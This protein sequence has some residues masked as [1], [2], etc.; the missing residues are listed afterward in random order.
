MANSNIF[1]YFFLIPCVIVLIIVNILISKKVEDNENKGAVRIAGNVGG[2]LASML[3]SVIFTLIFTSIYSLV[4]V[5]NEDLSHESYYYLNTY[6]DHKGRVHDL[7]SFKVYID[8]KTD[9]GLVLYKLIYQSF[10]GDSELV[11]QIP[12]TGFCEISE[13]PD[14]YWDAPTKVRA[15][16]YSSDNIKYLLTW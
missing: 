10:G 15:R 1:L 12:S 9:K 2:A 4:V 16:K 7:K 6:T 8:N 5:V 13:A 14:Y 11:D 3:I